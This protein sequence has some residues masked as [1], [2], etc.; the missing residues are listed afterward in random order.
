MSAEICVCGGEIP[1]GKPVIYN[2]IFL[3]TQYM[4]PFIRRY[5]SHFLALKDPPRVDGTFSRCV[6]KCCKCCYLSKFVAVC[7]NLSA[8]IFRGVRLRVYFLLRSAPCIFC[9]VQLELDFGQTQ[10]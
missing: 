1:R 4:H 9:G 7:R 8:P 10:V 6:E 2:L 3:F 5:S